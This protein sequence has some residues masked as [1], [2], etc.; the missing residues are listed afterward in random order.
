MGDWILPFRQPHVTV[1]VQGFE[2]REPH[3]QEGQEFSLSVGGI[4]SFASCLFLEVRAERLK[5]IRRSFDGKEERWRPYLPHLTVG[6]YAC[7]LQPRQIA[8]QIHAFRGLPPLKISGIFRRARVDA[9]S[10]MGQLT[11]DLDEP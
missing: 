2:H 11:Y 3:P 1:W 5:E 6:C 7:S 8:K 10:R 4:N 9:F